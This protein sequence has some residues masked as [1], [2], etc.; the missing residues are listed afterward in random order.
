MENKGKMEERK[1]RKENHK[2]NRAKQKWEAKNEYIHLG[3][4]EISKD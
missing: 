1:E 3:R 2:E 4:E